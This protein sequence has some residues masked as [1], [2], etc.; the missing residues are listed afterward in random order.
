VLSTI[1]STIKAS[2]VRDDLKKHRSIHRLTGQMAD[3]V[4]K[5]SA[6]KG[7][8]DN[9]TVLILSFNNL[10][11]FVTETVD[12]DLR[13][14]EQFL[15]KAQPIF[16]NKIIQ[17]VQTEQ[18]KLRQTVLVKSPRPAK[19]DLSLSPKTRNKKAIRRFLNSL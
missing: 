16:E 6:I 10:E 9:L 18:K 3:T 8:T 4:M 19:I 12:I 7:S 14:S 5:A 17:S 13:H 2:K 15:E 1:W 11:S